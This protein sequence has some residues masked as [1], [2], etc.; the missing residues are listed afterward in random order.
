MPVNLD[1]P[2]NWKADI[3]AS[4]DM[5][6]GWFMTFAPKAFRKTRIRTTKNVKEA[7]EQTANLTDIK[8]E[9]LKAWQGCFQRCA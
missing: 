2:Q 6:N 9:T 1:K 3:A 4:V 5:Y 8:P 7:L